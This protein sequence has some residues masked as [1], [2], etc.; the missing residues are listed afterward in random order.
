M[1]IMPAG[2]DI[3]T[4][5]TNFIFSISHALAEAA[6]NLTLEVLKEWT[7][8]YSKV[9]TSQ[10]TACLSYVVPWLANLDLF[11]KPCLEDGVESRKQVAEIIRSLVAITISE[12]RVSS[13]MMTR[14]RP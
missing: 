4:N 10:K 13:D 3:P 9:D 1:L 7:I 5:A 2:L 14:A 6:P 11:S 8:G 12:R